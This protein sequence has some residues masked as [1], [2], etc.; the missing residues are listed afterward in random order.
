M[1]MQTIAMF[2]LVALAVGGVIWVFVYPILS[3]ERLVE[4]RQQSVTRADPGAL[5]AA[6]CHADQ[7]VL[8]LAPV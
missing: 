3:G 1:P 7:D 5:R 2:V 6:D 8:P 4:K